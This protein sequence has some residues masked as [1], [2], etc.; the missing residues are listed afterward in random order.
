MSS[1]DRIESR[2]K[3]MRVHCPMVECQTLHGRSGGMK[4]ICHEGESCDNGGVGADDGDAGDDYE[5]G[6]DGDDCDAG[7]GDDTD[8]DA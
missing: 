8:D 4:R 2:A 3:D 5:D 7:D 1:G 6:D